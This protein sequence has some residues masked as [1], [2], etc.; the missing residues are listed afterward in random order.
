MTE[1]FQVPLLTADGVS[2]DIKMAPLIEW[3]H[4]IGIKTLF[5]CQGGPDRSRWIGR[6]QVRAFVTDPYVMFA[7]AHMRPIFSWRQST[8]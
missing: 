1:H 3:L 7:D 8:N 6:T 5:S 2:V 4:H